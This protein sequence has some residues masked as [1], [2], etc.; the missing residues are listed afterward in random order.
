MQN[1]LDSKLNTNGTNI[2]KD[3]MAGYRFGGV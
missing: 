1:H 2:K 3:R